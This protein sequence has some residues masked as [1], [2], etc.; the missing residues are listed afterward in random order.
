MATSV[1]PHLNNTVCSHQD[2]QNLDLGTRPFDKFSEV[3]SYSLIH[4]STRLVDL[5]F[6]SQ[7]IQLYNDTT[8]EIISLLLAEK[9]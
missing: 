5:P 8:F 3:V 1:Q 2:D 7:Y 9:F 6:E 4:D